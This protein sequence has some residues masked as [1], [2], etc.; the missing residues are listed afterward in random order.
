M[1][2]AYGSGALMAKCNIKSAFR[3]LPVPPDD[4]RLLGFQFDNMFFVYSALPMGCSISCAGFEHSFLEWALERRAG[5]KQVVHYLDD[6]LF[7]GASYSER[8]VYLVSCFQ[9]LTAELGVS[10]AEEKTEGPSM[11][12][13]F[14]GI[15]LD[16]ESQ[17]SRLPM[18]NSP[19]W[20]CV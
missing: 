13:T 12:L 18:V 14:L 16:T 15:E 2:K 20:C 1:V 11:V 10:L 6:F 19:P 8:G 17:C 5:L 4:F 7:C 3:L 9:H